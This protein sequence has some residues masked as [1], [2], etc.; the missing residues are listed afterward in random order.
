MT[1]IN[2]NW[3]P[4]GTHWGLNIRHHPINTGPMTPGAGHKI[5]LHTTEGSTLAGADATLRGNDD[6]PHFLID[7]NGTVIQFVALNQFSKALRHNGPPTNTAGCIQIEMVG[8]AA[9]PP[10]WFSKIGALCCLIEHR[11]NVPRRVPHAFAE[12][13]HA[14]RFGGAQFLKVTGYVGHEHV[15]ENDHVDPG[16]FDI[17]AMFTEMQKLTGE[18]R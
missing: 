9:T 8:F 11:V 6:E 5:V 12:P 17:H 18:H 1:P 7:K 14:V 10:T 3:L 15:P 2:P 13:G 16:A 4:Q